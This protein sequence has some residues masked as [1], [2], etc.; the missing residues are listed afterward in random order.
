L[1]NLSGGVNWFMVNPECSHR[2]IDAYFLAAVW[3]FL[4]QHGRLIRSEGRKSGL[5]LQT[6]V[7]IATIT[8]L[9]GPAAS[10]VG[11]GT[12]SAHNEQSRIDRFW[13]ALGVLNCQSENAH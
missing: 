1:G 4:T 8:A 10:E 6:K 2:G 13:A 9:V 11:L 7:N 5:G 12:G 3:R